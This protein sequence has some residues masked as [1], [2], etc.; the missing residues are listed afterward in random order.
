MKLARYF[1]WGSLAL[2]GILAGLFPDNRAWAQQPPAPVK[3][4]PQ[5]PVLALTGPAGM[6]RGTTLEVT[7][8]GTNL[9]DPTGITTSFPA[10]VTIPRDNKNG[11]ENTRL[12]VRLEVPANASLGFHGLRLATKRGM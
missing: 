6:Q 11:Q 10:K 5:A 9:A 1:L 7:L 2:L 8:T 12:R 4:N 3:P